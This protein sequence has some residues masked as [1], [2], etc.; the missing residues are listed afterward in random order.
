MHKQG[1][2]KLG[3]T[4]DMVPEGTFYVWGNLSNLPHPVNDGITFFEE[5]IK[6]KVRFASALI[7]NYTPYSISACIAFVAVA[8]KNAKFVDTLQ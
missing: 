2:E 4:V 3:I 6:E 7:V 5:C 8:D 1:I